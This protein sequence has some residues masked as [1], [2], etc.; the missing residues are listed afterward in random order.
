MQVVRDDLVGV[1]ALWSLALNAPHAA[2]AKSACDLL[3]SLHTKLSSGVA[4]AKRAMW[5]RFV[6]R[7]MAVVL[8]ALEALRTDG[9]EAAAH[10][11]RMEAALT[12]LRSFLV[13]VED[14]GRRS[15]EHYTVQWKVLFGFRDSPQEKV[16]LLPENPTVGQLRTEAGA[17]IAFAP[18]RV[19][20]GCGRLAHA[21]R[22]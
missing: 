21:D 13:V 8:E 9:A 1:D 4:S 10:E 18:N 6:Q 22:H 5:E 7:C 11:H 20:V 12:L 14:A 3:V 19:R 15:R 16:V 17:K 2:V